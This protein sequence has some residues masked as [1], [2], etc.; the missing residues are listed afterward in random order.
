MI[1]A[2]IDLE[3]VERGSRSRAAERNIGMRMRREGEVGLK[4]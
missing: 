2:V 4:G 3:V 1:T